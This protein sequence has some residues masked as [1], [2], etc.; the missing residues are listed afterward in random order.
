MSTTL[1]L[2]VEATTD[3]SWEEVDLSL[4]VKTD[5]LSM[6]DTGTSLGTS[7]TVVLASG[8]HGRMDTM[9]ALM[10]TIALPGFS[11]TSHWGVAIQASWSNEPSVGGWEL[12]LGCGNT[13]APVSDEGMYFG[14][15]IDPTSFTF[16]EKFG[17][18][19]IVGE[20]VAVASSVSG[21]VTYRSDRQDAVLCQAKNDDG[22]S[23]GAARRTNSPTTAM[24]NDD[25]YL[26]VGFG[27]NSSKSQT[28]LEGLKV[29]Y[30]L[31]AHPVAS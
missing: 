8:V 7:S 25:Q 18:A 27:N 31:L 15:Q 10:Y 21:V 9:D 29:Y 28:S 5:T 16:A 4:A 24:S 23:R 30:R 1:P 26:M 14:V 19:P 6:E 2:A 3:S 12:Y 20:E 17:A 13:S 22:S 11:R